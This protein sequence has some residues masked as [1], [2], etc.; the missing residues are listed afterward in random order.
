MDSTSPSC[1]FLP[2]VM[3]ATSHRGVKRTDDADGF[4]DGTEQYC[5]IEWLYANLKP[6]LS[7]TTTAAS[8]THD[9]VKLFSE[10]PMPPYMEECA[11]ENGGYGVRFWRTGN[12][13]LVWQDYG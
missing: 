7:H 12:Q 9:P 2:T 3:Q 11:T 4:E 13:E 1:P 10:V 6:Q 5:T 8:N